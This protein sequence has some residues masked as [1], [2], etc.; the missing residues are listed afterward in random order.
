MKFTENWMGGINDQRFLS[1]IIMPGSHDAGM[2]TK[3]MQDQKA[4]TILGIGGYY[5]AGRTQDLTVGDQCAAGIRF[6]DIRLADSFVY[7]EKRGKKVRMRPTIRAQHSP[8][9]GKNERSTVFGEKGEEIFRGVREFLRAN[10]SE[11]V[12]IRLSKCMDSVLKK[13]PRLLDE[14]LGWEFLFKT[15]FRC[16]LMYTPI[17]EMRGKAI[18][19]FDSGGE[20]SE[21]VNQAEGIHPFLN[22][23][24]GGD[25]VKSMVDRGSVKGIVS[26][27]A[28]SDAGNFQDVMG[29]LADYASGFAKVKTT[30]K[31]TQTTHWGLHV[32]GEC[33]CGDQ[34]HLFMLYWT[35]TN[36]MPWNNVQKRTK[37]NNDKTEGVTAELEN[38]MAQFDRG[39]CEKHVQPGY[40]VDDYALFE[41]IDQ[42]DP[43]YAQLRANIIRTYLNTQTA[44]T[45]C[46]PN[47]VMYDFA[48]EQTSTEIINL[49]HRDILDECTRVSLEGGQK[50]QV[51]HYQGF[52]IP[53]G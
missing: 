26:C 15:D 14:L 1:D 13:L 37:T 10:P 45:R 29:D 41:K 39:L 8:G 11:I 53:M 4:R 2:S 47:V 42:S 9:T 24:K 48:N 38:V 16:N 22:V 40:S 21:L 19:M 34:P 5:N 35:Y 46:M 50:S 30:G 44:K 7:G 36:K 32:N 31:G 3:A 12:L 23:T 6:F 49:N 52:S 28:Y 20:W 25:S 17:G 43:N 51:F 33:G 27:G 18:V